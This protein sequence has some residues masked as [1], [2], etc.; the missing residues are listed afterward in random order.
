MMKAV[1]AAVVENKNWNSKPELH[2][3]LRQYRATPHPSTCFSSLQLTFGRVLQT[4]LPDVSR[5]VPEPKTE[6]E[7]EE[8]QETATEQRIGRNEEIRR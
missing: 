4:R 7:Q 8:R 2:T 3:F 6:I 5:S 1:K